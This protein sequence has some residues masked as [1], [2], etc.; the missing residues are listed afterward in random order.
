MFRA[1]S[2]GT[3]GNRVDYGAFGRLL[4]NSAN[5]TGYPLFGLLVGRASL[6]LVGGHTVNI[7]LLELCH[8]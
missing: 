5:A 7:P 3:P 4:A 6:L 2:L 1:D 8:D